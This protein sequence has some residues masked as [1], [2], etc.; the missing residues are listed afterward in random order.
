MKLD[1]KYILSI[2]TLLI[3]QIGITI[4]IIY[5]LKYKNIPI[6]SFS[7]NYRYL[8]LVLLSFPV[9]LMLSLN[10]SK[11]LKLMLLTCLSIIFGIMIYPTTIN[12]DNTILL[13]VLLI[14]IGIFVGLSILTF[15]MVSKGYNLD[16]MRSY[17]FSMLIGLII[18]GLILLFYS[19]SRLYATYL[20]VGTII[21]SLYVMY[22]TN[23]IIKKRL[24]VID[25]TVS[26][27]LDFVNLFLYIFQMYNRNK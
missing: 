15:Y 20:V 14:T 22:D 4:S 11:V 24:G 13:N 16:G 7:K 1:L 5:Y 17:L 23:N 26:F 8:F 21:F 10:I 6:E 3:I 12:V 2:Y 27:Y 25:S 18:V 9:L 19:N